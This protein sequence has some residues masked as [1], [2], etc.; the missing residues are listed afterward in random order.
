MKITGKMKSRIYLRGASAVILMAVGCSK[1]N[2]PV[3]NGCGNTGWSEKVSNEITAFSNA[4]IAYSNDPTPANCLSY[5]TA[6]EGYLNA[7]EKVRLC[8]PSASKTEF[9]QS[10][11][12]AKQ[13]INDLTCD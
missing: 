6:A 9:Q 3:D 1:D 11:D 10:I 7:L 13:E 2:N 12:E 8:V 5:K 4:A